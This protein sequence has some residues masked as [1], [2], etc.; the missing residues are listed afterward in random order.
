[1][2]AHSIQQKL[3]GEVEAVSRSSQDAVSGSEL[4]LAVLPVSV[5][6][7]RYSYVMGQTVTS[8]G[9]SLPSLFKSTVFYCFAVLFLPCNSVSGASLAL[10]RG[11]WKTLGINMLGLEV[12]LP[13]L[14]P[15]PA[16]QGAHDSLT[17]ECTFPLHPSWSSWQRPSR[18]LWPGAS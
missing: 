9:N 15:A 13:A 14:L 4:P 11:S 5:S 2:G 7:Y 17:M 12:R 6:C 10:Q 1:M 3:T 8:V 16:S 18:A